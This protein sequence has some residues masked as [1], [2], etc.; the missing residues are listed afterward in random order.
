MECITFNIYAGTNAKAVERALFA[1]RRQHNVTFGMMQEAGGDDITQAVQNAGFDTH[2]SGEYRTFWLP[3]AWVPIRHYVRQLSP[4]AWYREGG[5]TPVYA[6]ALCSILCD[7][8][9][10]TVTAISAHAPSHVQGMDAPERRLEAWQDMFGPG[11]LDGIAE[12][13]ETHA[14]VCGVD[15]NLDPDTGYVRAG[16]KQALYDGTLRPLVTGKP[17]HGSRREIDFIMLKRGGPLRGAGNWV[18]DSPSDHRIK[19]HSLAWINR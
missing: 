18:V 4:Q 17:T 2:V 8:W 7:R 15:A 16:M 3:S 12:E 11:G 14:V 1:Q 9:G 19:G 13:A 10:R 6:K 5:N